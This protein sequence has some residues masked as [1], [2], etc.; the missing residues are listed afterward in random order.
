[1]LLHIVDSLASVCLIECRSKDHV[2]YSVSV[3]FRDLAK[4]RLNPGELSLPFVLDLPH[5]LPS[6]SMHRLGVG[7]VGFQIQYKLR[8]H[9]GGCSK[10]IPVAIAAAAL[11]GPR[12]PFVMQ[13]TAQPVFS[14]NG[15]SQG[16]VTVAASIYSI[17]LRKGEKMRV[18]LCCRNDSLVNIQ[19]VEVKVVELLNWGLKEGYTK[20]RAHKVT[21]ASIDNLELAG[22]ETRNENK[23][24]LVDG[25]YPTMEEQI[26]KYSTMHDD[27][28]SGQNSVELEIPMGA[29]DSY[30]GV[31]VDIRHYLKVKFVTGTFGS[32]PFIKIPLKIGLPNDIPRMLVAS[33]SSTVAK[34]EED[35][36]VSGCSDIGREL[37][38]ASAVPIPYSTDKNCKHNDKYIESQPQSWKKASPNTTVAVTGGRQDESEAQTRLQDLV[39]LPPSMY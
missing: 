29:R 1:M 16:S 39:P 10:S 22:L 38:L 17:H 31:L 2:F 3:P 5:H 34:V 27:L 24:K 8:A 20:T 7:D 21:L 36:E 30:M 12:V 35:R 18:S 23:S 19:R 6:S 26:A 11:E 28:A 9:M 4:T 32:Q 33:A 37:P 14:R 13:P 15:S 25:N